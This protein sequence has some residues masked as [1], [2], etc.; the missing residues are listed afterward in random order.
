VDD[1]TSRNI[2]AAKLGIC[3]FRKKKRTQSGSRQRMG[4]DLGTVREQVAGCG[5]I[6]IHGMKSLKNRYI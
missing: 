6:K 5:V 4:I 1:A 3:G 2:R